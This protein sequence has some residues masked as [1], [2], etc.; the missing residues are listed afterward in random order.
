MKKATTLLFLIS[1]LLLTNSCSKDDD[2][3]LTNNKSINPPEW[4]HGTWLDKS[5]P[6]W[7]QVGGFKFTNDN[8]VDLNADGNENLSY[9]EGLESGIKNGS[10]SIE[11]TIT[12]DIYEFK[13]IS[14]GL[15]S[16]ILHFDKGSSN[17]IIYDLNET[18]DVILTK[19]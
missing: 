12:N 18:Y 17:T 4:I 5:E 15:T 2:Q 7:A 6:T 13:V 8:I 11:E 1:Y 16:S 3:S 9:K 19:Q 10:I 14:F